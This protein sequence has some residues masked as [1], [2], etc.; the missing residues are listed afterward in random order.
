MFSFFKKDPTKKLKKQYDR[1]LE[2][3]M[4]A[5][6]NGNIKG[7]AMITAEAEAIWDKVVE[8]EKKA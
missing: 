6:R 2:E 8:L 5:Q 3:A 4:H 7:Y 1:K